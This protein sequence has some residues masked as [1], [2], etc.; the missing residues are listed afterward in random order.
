MT[1]CIALYAR[2]S[3]VGQDPDNQLERLRS[4]YFARK[5]GEGMHRE[6]ID[7]ASGANWRR[8]SLDAMMN[9]AKNGKIRHI[10]ATKLDRL[11]RSTINLLTLM[12][13]LDSWNVTVEFLDQPIDTS[14]PSGKMMLTV[15]GAMAEF[16]RELIRDRTKDGLARAKAQGKVGGRPKRTL[17]AYQIAKA[18]ELIAEN[19]NISQT[20]LAEQ[21]S[22]ISRATLIKLLKGEGII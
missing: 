2:V 12:Q 6:Y 21:F 16:E 5:Y 11:A 18:K 20:E 14:T 10:I 15:L 17:S 9:D 7:Q 1:G 19:P 8:P 22:G 3:T 4:V 13:Q